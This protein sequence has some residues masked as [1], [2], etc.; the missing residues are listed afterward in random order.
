MIDYKRTALDYYERFG[1]NV[2]PTGT[3]SN[4]KHPNLP[5]TNDEVNKDTGLHHNYK[6]RALLP[7]EIESFTI[8]RNG[9]EFSAWDTAYCGGLCIVTGVNGWR[10]IDFDGYESTDGGK[11]PVRFDVVE[12]FLTRLGLDPY[13]YEWIVES[14]N[15]GWH[16]W[17]LSNGD[18]P[19]STGWNKLPGK[20]GYDSTL[21]HAELRW[22]NI[23][24]VAPPTVI[25]DKVYRFRNVEIPAHPPA[26]VSVRDIVYALD[27]VVDVPEIPAIPGKI[28]DTV[29]DSDSYYGVI[30][31]DAKE[32]A[33]DQFDMVS[34]ICQHLKTDYIK[35]APGG[36]TRIG[37]PGAGHGGW[38]VTQDGRTWNTFEGGDG[39]TGGDC[40]ALVAYTEFKTTKPSKEEWRKVFD[41]VSKVT[42][43]D[44]SSAPKVVTKVRTTAGDNGED[45][46]GDNATGST[47]AHIVT[48]YINARYELR[49]NMM[50]HRIQY[51]PIDGE[52]WAYLGDS[53][54]NTWATRVEKETGK[55]IGGERFYRYVDS[56]AQ[57]HPYDPLRDWF[58]SLPKWD[59]TT[60]YI[61]A[62]IQTLRTE[63]PA[64]FYADLRKWLIGA[65][66][67]GY[68]GAIRRR[69]LNE[70]FLILQSDEQG[71]GKTTW[72]DYLI[73]PAL[74]EY[75]YLGTISKDK[76]ST[77]IQSEHWISIN[78]ELETFR[79]AD[80]KWLKALLSETEYTYRPPYARV[81]EKRPRR[82][83][84]CGSTNES[85]FLTDPTGNRRYLVHTV[86]NIDTDRLYSVPIEMVWAQA[87]VL[88][89][90][91]VPHW[92][93]ADEIQ[94]RASHTAKYVGE[95]FYDELLTRYF[96][97]GVE[98]E[99]GAVFKTTTDISIRIVELFDKDHSSTVNLGMAGDTLTRDGVPRPNAERMVIP[100]G[101]S[102]RKCGFVRAQKKID[103]KPT[104]GFW[105]I[106]RVKS[107]RDNGGESW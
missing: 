55:H 83:S 49:R 30:H 61:Q 69:T 88:H 25:G 78:D 37:K 71:A 27:G 6:K 16:V 75:R 100:L 53:E 94:E 29:P 72:L 56:I 46:D 64:L 12:G 17:L 60:D 105:V 21:H 20:P 10:C 84:Y 43:V 44:L 89:E 102:L 65:Y 58:D 22:A 4:S 11:E 99:P 52:S 15:G 59:G 24:T 28:V 13:T 2:L 74:M 87:R 38:Y 50:N 85:T 63:N 36:E 67:T 97:P 57:K 93:T 19:V 42:G 8:K 48:A 39:K 18:L 1:C 81:G 14:G 9:S 73:P 68:Y 92:L 98:G 26:L 51:R 86:S 66:A 95:S 40:F 32:T 103:R 101:S 80:H 96:I 7:G 70:L 54:L 5:Y 62:L 31:K 45:E 79:K 77:A 91:G 90:Q 107:G 34:W 41:V 104:Y 33:R 82:I 106:E 47:P 35:R 23:I 3:G 76:D